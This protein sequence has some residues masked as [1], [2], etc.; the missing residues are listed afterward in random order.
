[1]KYALSLLLT[2]FC[3]ELVQAG[4]TEVVDP[5]KLLETVDTFIKGSNFDQALAC[6]TH[7]RFAHSAQKCA[8]TC[9]KDGCFSVCE[10][11]SD[12]KSEKTVGECTNDSV[13]IYSDRGEIDQITRSDFNMHSGNMARRLL[14]TVGDIVSYDLKVNIDRIEPSTMK[15]NR[16]TPEE[17]EVPSLNIYTSL[18]IP[19][20]KFQPELII[21]VLQSGPAVAQIARFRLHKTTWYYLE[22][23]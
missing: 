8:L 15:L 6:G 16:N 19:D 23:Y 18:V 1:M 17:T 10:S 14:E 21:S 3:F 22:G 11:Q 2:I 5:S 4:I 13:T 7:A 12:A 9:S 20:S